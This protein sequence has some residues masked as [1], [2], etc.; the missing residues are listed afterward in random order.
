MKLSFVPV[1]I[2]SEE[3]ADSL[4]NGSVFMRPLKAFGSWDWM[5]NNGDPV[6]SNNFRGDIREGIIK[7]YVGG[8]SPDLS[9]LPSDLRTVIK[10]AAIIDDSDIKYFR[11]F[12]LYCLRFSH[13][14][15]LFE[16]P[17]RE[18]SEFGDTAVIIT[19]FNEFIRRILVSIFSQYADP[20]CILMDEIQYFSS[21]ETQTAVPMFNKIDYYAWQNE[22]RFAFAKLD[23]DHPTSSAGAKW[24][25][26]ESDEPVILNIGRI[27]DIAFKTS[28]ADFLDLNFD[29]ASI[30]KPVNIEEQYVKMIH[31]TRAQMA[32]HQPS[33]QKFIFTV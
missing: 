28:I 13:D 18:L 25:I 23:G 32:A 20:L 9:A 2:V 8:S 4:M 27:N 33:A 16:R 24:P 29:I 7:Y 19:D 22:F 31:D 14:G 3:W 6:L 5:D 21:K 11:L 12:C 30:S 17:S 26:I 10:N 1:K 15:E